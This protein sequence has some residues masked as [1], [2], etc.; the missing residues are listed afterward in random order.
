M[1]GWET[2]WIFSV[3]GRENLRGFLS[4]SRHVYLQEFCEF[5]WGDFMNSRNGNWNSKNSTTAFILWILKTQIINSLFLEE[6]SFHWMPRKT[7]FMKIGFQIMRKRSKIA[8]INKK[9][10]KQH[11][12]IPQFRFDPIKCQENYFKYKVCN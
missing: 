10:N 1:S 12:L 9:I 8:K 2:S 5:L 11:K 7:Y 6:S 4:F 3:R